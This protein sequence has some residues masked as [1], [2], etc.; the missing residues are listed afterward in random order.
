LTGS[1]I[2]GSAYDL[3]LLFI[4]GINL[5]KVEMVRLGNLFAGDNLSCYNPLQRP[6]EGIHSLCF[7]PQHGQIVHQFLYR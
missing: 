3:Q 4:S 2:G 6:G 1:Y 7:K 5:T